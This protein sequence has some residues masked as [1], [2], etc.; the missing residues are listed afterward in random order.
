MRLK[1]NQL[2]AWLG[3]VSTS[4][5]AVPLGQA[6]VQVTDSVVVVVDAVVL[7]V[8]VARAGRNRPIHHRVGG[9]LSAST[10]SAAR[11]DGASLVA[12]LVEFDCL[13]ADHDGDGRDSRRCRAVACVFRVAG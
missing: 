7:L 4:L 11:A 13:R 3:A 8:Q 1:L 10:E 5:W 12:G 9:H 2:G 6:Q